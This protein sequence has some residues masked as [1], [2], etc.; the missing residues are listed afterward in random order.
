MLEAIKGL[1]IKGTCQVLLILGWKAVGY[2]CWALSTLPWSQRLG[3]YPKDLRHIDFCMSCDVT[4]KCW[5]LQAM[6]LVD[7]AKRTHQEPEAVRPLKRY[8]LKWH[9]ALGAAL[10]A[11]FVAARVPA[12]AVF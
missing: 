6:A 8:A 12:A 5:C 10:T 4:K 9:M 3:H 1:Y 2:T 7:F 11:G